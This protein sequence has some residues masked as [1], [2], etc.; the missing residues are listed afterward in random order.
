MFK[1]HWKVSVKVGFVIITKI[2]QLA[3]WESSIQVFS[4]L[5]PFHILDTASLQ[6]MHTF[7]VYKALAILKTVGWNF[8]DEI[9]GF[10]KCTNLS[11]VPVTTKHNK[12]FYSNFCHI[13]I[14]CKMFLH[15]N[16]GSHAQYLKLKLETPFV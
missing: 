16:L 15:T 14:I 5:C 6:H 4:T 9:S 10:E 3:L 13:K 12:Y 11:V 7:S 8:A 1:R 2:M